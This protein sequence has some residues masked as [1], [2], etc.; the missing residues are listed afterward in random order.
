MDEATAKPPTMREQNLE[1]T[2][3]AILVAA[4]KLFA[5]RGYVETGVRDIASEAMVNPALIARYYGSKLELFQVAL[6]QSLDVSLF[7]NLARENFGEAVAD[8]FCQSQPDMA[9]VIPML[10]FAAGDS[11][12][13]NVALALIGSHVLKP[14][15]QWFGTKDA[16]ERAAQLMALITGFYTYRLMLPLPSFEGIPSPATQAWLAQSLQEIID[17]S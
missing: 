1:R 7:T 3:H 9:S 5:E 4:Q 10:I 13:R 8:A 17:R 2:K 14:L 16:A 6:G 15:E 12:A 11:E